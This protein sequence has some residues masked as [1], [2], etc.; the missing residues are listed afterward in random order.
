MFS[1]TTKK[2]VAAIFGSA[3]LAA[4]AL[5][6]CGSGDGEPDSITAV[7]LSGASYDG[8]F[9]AIAEQFRADTG[10]EI[11]VINVGFAGLRD[12]LLTAMAGGTGEFDVI[13]I[14][15]QWTG[16]FGQFVVPLNDQVAAG[17]QAGIIPGILDMYQLDGDQVAVPL[18]A[19]AETLFYRA[20]LLEQAG[21]AVPTTWDEFDAVAEFFTNN[22]DFPGVSGTS[23]KAAEGHV[24]TAFNNRY[25]GFGGGVL[26]EPGSVLDV[27]IAERALA[28]LARTA[29][30]F[31]PSGALQAS[32]PEVSAQFAAGTV[33]MT[34]MM[35]NTM[36]PFVTAQT[37]ENHV[38]GKVGVAN[39]PGGHGEAGGWGLAIPRSSNA[40]GLAWEFINLVTSPEWDLYCFAN[41]GKTGIYAASY[42][43]PEMVNQF[44]ID[45]VQA[46][47]EGSMPRPRGTNAGE[48]STMLT[49]VITRFLAG[50]IPDART[51]AEEMANRY[52]NIS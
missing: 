47:T 34:E 46:A 23:I 42:Q 44:F 39:M 49:D 31:S 4:S 33:V 26:G 5:T 37:D 40:H 35:P 19:Q 29:H 41:F 12:M 20:D 24:V 25:F 21:L 48:I 38:L 52:A 16:E 50:Q 8:C 7:V 27:D 3:A 13:M 2:K 36:V 15:Y 14:A 9:A 18:I 45:G 30:E 6:G 32:F 22:P 51:A 1:S 43:A 17:P 28:H 10:K 11:E